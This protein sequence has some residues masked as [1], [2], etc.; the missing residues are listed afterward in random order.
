MDSYSHRRVRSLPSSVQ[1]FFYSFSFSF[2][3]P[4]SLELVNVNNFHDTFAI[5]N[6][7]N[8]AA[9]SAVIALPLIPPG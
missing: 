7:L 8:P 2:S 5:G 9:G 4:F 3:S 1:L 6:N